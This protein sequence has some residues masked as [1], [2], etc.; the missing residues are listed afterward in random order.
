[1]NRKQGFALCMTVLWSVAFSTA[2]HNWTI[3]VSMGICMGAA[4][5]LLESDHKGDGE[6]ENEK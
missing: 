6:N 1:M 3:G 5:G 2:M 4:F